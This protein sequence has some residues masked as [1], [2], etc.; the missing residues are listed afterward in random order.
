MKKFLDFTLVILFFACLASN[1]LPA[2]V[3]QALGLIFIALIVAHNVLNRNFYR[4]GFNRRRIFNQTTIFL[5]ASGILAILISGA[6]L[7]NYFQ[8]PDI[9]W[10]SIHLGAAIFSTILLMIHLL[11]HIRGKKLY[12]ATALA[13]ILAV[14][15]IFGLP[16]VDRWFHT[17]KV[18]KNILSGEKLAVEDKILVIYFSRVG[19]TDFP[20]EV[21]AVSGA[22]LMLD[23]KKI[24]GNAQM[25]AEL[26]QSIVGGEIFAIQTEKTYPADYSETTKVAKAE[27]DANE[28][29]KLK[30]LPEINAYDKIILIYPLWWGD[31]PKPVENFLL[32][33]KFKG[34]IYPI[35]THGGGGLGK[36][37][38]TLKKY[39]EIGEP[40]EIYSSDIPSSRKIIFDWL[41]L[42]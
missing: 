18:D 4:A 1:F 10:R 30:E 29:P 8:V 11:R 39:A 36:S 12:A 31:L 42:F 35:V 34:K 41:S 40:L 23:D 6:A 28:L 22:S 27:F 7:A 3:H 38:E 20:A 2:Q 9:N 17:V 37:I 14:G 33:A 19:N 26:V 21:D 32:T 24:I 13:F 5:F 25:I 15:A 16:Y